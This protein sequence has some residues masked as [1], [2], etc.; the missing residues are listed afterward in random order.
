MCFYC[1][2]HRTIKKGKENGYQRWFCKDCKRYF[3]G[4]RRLTKEDVNSRRNGHLV[5]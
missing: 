1:G 4:R 2:S 5:G 3:I